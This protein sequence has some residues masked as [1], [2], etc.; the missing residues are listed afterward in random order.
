MTPPQRRLRQQKQQHDYDNSNCDM[1]MAAAVT[2]TR[3]QRNGDGS[4]M[5]LESRRLDLEESAQGEISEAWIEITQ[6]IRSREEQD[7]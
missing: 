1:M 3:L 5:L 6:K 4:T 2:T 7:W